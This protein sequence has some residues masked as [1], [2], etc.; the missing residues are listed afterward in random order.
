MTVTQ[1]SGS[2]ATDQKPVSSQTSVCSLS[3]L[4]HQIRA[5]ARGGEASAGRTRGPL[6]AGRSLPLRAARAEKE[7]ENV[8]ASQP[9]PSVLGQPRQGGHSLGL[10]GWAQN[11]PPNILFQK[12]KEKGP[13]Q[14]YTKYSVASSKGC[15]EFLALCSTEC[16]PVMC[17]PPLPWPPALPARAGGS[18][19]NLLPQPGESSGE[20]LG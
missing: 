6:A 14:L 20:D 17:P 7:Q 19:F 9:Q 13:E 4:R 1:W 16:V 2:S 18:C 8:P 5:P 15:T 10:M 3:L 12:V 11:H